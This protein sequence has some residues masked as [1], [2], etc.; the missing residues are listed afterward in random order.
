MLQNQHKTMFSLSYFKKSYIILIILS[1]VSTSVS[2]QLK[3]R[4]IT[5]YQ[6]KKYTPPINEIVAVW[7]K[8]GWFLDANVGTRLSGATSSN[9]NLSPGLNTNLS[10]GYLFSEKFGIKGRYDFNSFKLTPGFNGQSES[11]GRMHSFSLE[12][13]TD[14]ITL[15]SGD[16]IRN[17]R[18]V[19]H[20]GAG[21]SSYGNVDFRKFREE[22]IAPWEDPFIK[23]YDDMG[24]FIFGVTPQYHISG[25]WSLNLDLSTFMLI[26]QSR[27][28]DHFSKE[29]VTC[30]GNVTTL[31]LGLTFRP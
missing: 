27:T 13:C 9:V 11:I 2:A 8:L 16:K 5:K 22:E 3:G 1:I 19:L 10:I 20:G 30:L 29:R 14:L 4:P 28:F 18:F 26:K 23:G 7:Y 25:R 12:A 21:L 6:E 17:W 31:S 15:I 24:H